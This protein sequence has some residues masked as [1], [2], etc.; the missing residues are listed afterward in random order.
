MK[1]KKE[2]QMEYFL[3]II[4]MLMFGVILITPVN[5]DRVYDDIERRGEFGKWFGNDCRAVNASIAQAGGVIPYYQNR[6]DN[7]SRWQAEVRLGN[8]SERRIWEKA[9]KV[10]QQDR[11]YKRWQAYRNK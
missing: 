5:Y 10:R 1:N 8:K 2:Q 6:V 9:N 11:D 7:N 4:G 3:G